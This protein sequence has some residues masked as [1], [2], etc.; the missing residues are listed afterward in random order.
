MCALKETLRPSVKGRPFSGGKGIAEQIRS[1]EVNV[2]GG[3][4]RDQLNSESLPLS[5]LPTVTRADYHQA[6]SD[7]YQALRAATTAQVHELYAEYLDEY[8]Y[9]RKSNLRRK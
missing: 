4:L 2:N 7:I 1:R 5:E 9:W 8:D 3:C 6:D